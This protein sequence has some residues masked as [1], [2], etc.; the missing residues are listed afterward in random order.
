MSATQ[1]PF[2]LGHNPH[3]TARDF[4]EA[5]CNAQALAWVRR[6][7]D[8]PGPVLAICGPSGCGKTHLA[9]VFA[10]KSGGLVVAAASLGSADVPRLLDQAPALAVEDGDRGADEAA[11]FHLYNL[12]REM[13][14]HLLFTGREAPSRWNLTL[15]DLRSRLASV[16]VAEIGPPDDEVLRAVLVKLFADRQITVGEEVPAWL[17]GRIE[18]SFAALR[19]AVDILDHA[20]L[21]GKRPVTVP[22]ARQALGDLE[23]F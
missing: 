5:P 7:P 6:W 16:P 3:L 18:R 14:R 1:I 2:D 19:R 12:A 15:A 10:E 23:Q 17:L 22:L 13:G 20:A 21:A 11:L 4:L 8:W 9:H